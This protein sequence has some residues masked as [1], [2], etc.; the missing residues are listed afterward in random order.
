M[1]L[2]RDMIEACRA[3]WNDNILK[4]VE[5]A[6][7][8]SESYGRYLARKFSLSTGSVIKNPSPE[9]SAAAANL[10]NA[11]EAVKMAEE[12][13]QLRK[14]ELALLLGSADKAFTPSGSVQWVRPSPRKTIDWPTVAAAVQ[15]PREIIDKHTK[16]SPVTPYVR[17]YWSK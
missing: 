5:P 3:F 13:A 6:I 7:D 9:L 12:H 17:G 2:E 10:R 8:E 16:E 14:N 11:Q 1:Q 4:R 15:V